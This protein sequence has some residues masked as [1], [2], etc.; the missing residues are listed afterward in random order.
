MHD[1][2]GDCFSVCVGRV[3]DVEGGMKC[4]FTSLPRQRCMDS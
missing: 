1:E 4:C 2:I 3:V